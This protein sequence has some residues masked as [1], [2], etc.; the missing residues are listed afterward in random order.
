MNHFLCEKNHAFFFDNQCY[1]C[2]KKVPDNDIKA[3]WLSIPS[4]FDLKEYFEPHYICFN[5]IKKNNITKTWK[6]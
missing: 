2:K 6:K 3:A 4:G 1:L 5:C